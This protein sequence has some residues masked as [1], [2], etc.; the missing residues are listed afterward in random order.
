MS[1]ETEPKTHSPDRSCAFAGRG[2]RAH[3]RC[4][5]RKL[6]FCDQIESESFLAGSGS[7]LSLSLSETRRGP[8]P[9]WRQLR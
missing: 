9:S 2:I 8:E 5:P 3:F 1:A 7:Q 6:C 4:S